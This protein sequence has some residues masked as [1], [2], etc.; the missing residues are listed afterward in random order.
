MKHRIL[1]TGLDVFV[2]ARSLTSVIGLKSSPRIRKEMEELSEG[3]FVFRCT[4]DQIAN[5]G[6]KVG[7]SAHGYT[8]NTSSP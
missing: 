3:L 6:S 7:G 2:L 4:I 8:Q 5:I 1:I